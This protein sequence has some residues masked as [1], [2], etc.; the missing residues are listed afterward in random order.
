MGPQ[1][2]Q[3]KVEVSRFERLNHVVK[4]ASSAYFERPLYYLFYGC[5]GAAAVGLIAGASFPWQ[6]YILLLALAGVEVHRTVTSGKS[7]ERT[8]RR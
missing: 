8:K 4:Q 2:H 7:N 6:F 1:N 3:P 5:L